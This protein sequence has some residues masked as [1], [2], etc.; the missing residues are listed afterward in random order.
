MQQQQGGALGDEEEWVCRAIA[1]F[2]MLCTWE[3]AQTG[4]GLLKIVDARLDRIV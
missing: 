4:E 1:K 3:F 2:T